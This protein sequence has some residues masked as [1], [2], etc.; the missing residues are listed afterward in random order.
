MVVRIFRGTFRIQDIQRKW[1]SGKGLLIVLQI[2][3][4]IKNPPGY[5]PVSQIFKQ[6]KRHIICSEMTVFQIPESMAYLK[7]KKSS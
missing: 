5:T 3:A 6:N 4:H 7:K 2:F 1:S